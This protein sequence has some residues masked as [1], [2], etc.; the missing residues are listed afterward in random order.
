MSASVVVRADIEKVQ[1]LLNLL[2]NAIKFTE[3]GGHVRLN[4][5]ARIPWRACAS[6]TPAWIPSTK[7]DA[8]FEPFVQ[9]DQAFTREGRGT[10]SDCR[11]AGTSRVPWAAT[12][13]WRA[14]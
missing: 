3:S 13:P 11:S 7:L 8:I 5:S 10:G 4:A 6:W 12:S 14:C 2:S 9:V 1:V